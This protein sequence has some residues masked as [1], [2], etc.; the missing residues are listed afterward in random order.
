MMAKFGISQKKLT[1]IM[2]RLEKAHLLY[3]ESGVKGGMNVRNDYILSDPIS[4]LAEFLEVA[5]AGLFR[6]TL[7]PAY[8]PPCIT[9][10]YTDVLLSDAPRV[11]PSNTDQQTLSSKQTADTVEKNLWDNV[12]KQLQL[13]ADTFNTFL[14]DTS[15]KGVEDGVA[16]ITT[17]RSYAKDWLENRMSNQ[18]RKVLAIELRM[19]G[20]QKIESVRCEI[21]QPGR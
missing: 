9:E 19:N 3:K 8:I 20:G 1:T 5:A 15:F 7:L 16:V 14:S 4:T 2:G 21:T 6:L 13:P 11:L 17:S 10:Q 18:I 12:L